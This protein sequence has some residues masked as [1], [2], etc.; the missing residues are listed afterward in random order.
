MFKKA[1][2]TC[3]GLFFFLFKFHMHRKNM[4]NQK[5]YQILNTSMQNMMIVEK[6]NI[7]QTL[8]ISIFM[9]LK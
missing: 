2:I 9:N 4:E 8:A 6:K 7:D 3:V 5:F 1:H